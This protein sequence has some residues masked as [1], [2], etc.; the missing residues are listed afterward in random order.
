MEKYFPPSMDVI[1]IEFEASFA[2]SPGFNVPDG[3]DNGNQNW[4]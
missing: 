3:S 2:N 1:S 4:G